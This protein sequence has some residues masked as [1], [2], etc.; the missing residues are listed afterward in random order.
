[1]RPLV[2]AF[3]L[4]SFRGVYSKRSDNQINH[5]HCTSFRGSSGNAEIAFLSES[6]TTS[7]SNYDKVSY[8]IYLLHFFIVTHR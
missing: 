8:H 1:M 2:P 6:T 7:K 4:S 3:K 5:N